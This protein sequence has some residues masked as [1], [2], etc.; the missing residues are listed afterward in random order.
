MS[1]KLVKVYHY[2]DKKGKEAIERTGRIEPSSSGAYGGGTYMT[3]ISPTAGRKVVTQNN[4]DGGWQGKETRGR[5]DYAIEVEIPAH[6]L[7]EPPS[8]EK[9]DIL[10][11]DGP[12]KLGDYKWKS[13]HK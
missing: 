11:H 9:R 7:R 1:G 3:T 8:S 13:M 12:V 10:I 5:A 2:T 4:W 6:R